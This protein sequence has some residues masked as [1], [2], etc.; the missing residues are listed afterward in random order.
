[1]AAPGLLTV[2]LGNG[3]VTSANVT[4]VAVSCGGGGGTNPGILCGSVYCN[5]ASSLCC[6]TNGVPACATKCTGGGT[7]QIT[8]DDAAD[9]GGDLICCGSVSG[10]TVNSIYCTQT[11]LCMPPKAFYCNPA[12]ANP[13]PNG[14]TCAPTANPTGYYRCF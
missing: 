10:T 12:A 1:M 7:T 3:T 5:P 9:C 4:N 11:S 13:C 8:C 6:V 14:G 2:T